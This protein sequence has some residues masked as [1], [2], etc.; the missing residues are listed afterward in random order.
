ML[1]FFKRVYED[2]E[3]PSDFNAESMTRIV[4]RDTGYGERFCPEFFAGNWKPF[5]VYK[6]APGGGFYGTARF[7]T[8]DE[9]HALIQKRKRWLSPTERVVEGDA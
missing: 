1:N 2:P 5:K 8:V 9:A 7:E 4:A 6:L 3:H